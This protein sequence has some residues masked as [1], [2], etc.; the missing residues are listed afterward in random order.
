MSGWGND[1]VV[2]GGCGHVGLP[3]GLALVDS[4]L[5]V[6]LFDTNDAAVELVQSGTMPHGVLL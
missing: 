5:S 4:G 3:L 1:V 6:S 2:L